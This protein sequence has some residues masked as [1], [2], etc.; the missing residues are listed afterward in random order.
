WEGQKS[1]DITGNLDTKETHS[2]LYV[3]NMKYFSRDYEQWVRFTVDSG[4]VVSSH[5]LDVERKVLRDEHVKERGGGYSH[6][7]WVEVNLCVGR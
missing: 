1:V 7:P 2:T 4:N 3:A 5:T 6:R